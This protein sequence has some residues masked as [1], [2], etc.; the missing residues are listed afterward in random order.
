MLEVLETRSSGEKSLTG[1]E[2]NNIQYI[3][4]KKCTVQK[5]IRKIGGPNGAIKLCSAA[6]PVKRQVLPYLLATESFR[7]E[8]TAN[9]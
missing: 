7:S 8:F 2:Q 3:L 1:F 5:T 6:A 9:L 4:F